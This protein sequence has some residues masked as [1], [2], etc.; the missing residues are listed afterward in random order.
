MNQGTVVSEIGQKQLSKDVLWGITFTACLT[1]A[2]LYLP[3]GF[4]IGLLIPLPLIFY[5]IKLGRLLS[6]LILCTVLA[7]VWMIFR[8]AGAQSGIFFLYFGLTGVILAEALARNL[9]VEKTVLVTVGVVLGAGAILLFA[10]TLFAPESFN[11]LTKTYLRENI[12]LAIA[13]YKDMGV[14]QEKIE[15]LQNSLESILYISIHIIPGFF[16]AFTL[17]TVWVNLLITRLILKKGHLFCPDFGSLNRWKSPEH[18]V[19]VAIGS[20]FLLLF[21]LSGLKV[22]GLNGL[23]VLIV[24]YMFQ[25]LAIISYYFEKKKFP[26]ILRGGIYTLLALQPFLIAAVMLAGF[27]DVWADFRCLKKQQ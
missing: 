23:I 16:V 17:F 4:V 19:W 12:E 9:S 5:R 14:P 10:Y 24:V 2:A 20:G 11:V 7:I 26:L 15:I 18:L 22:L 8:K 6:A 21:P 3:V 27:L 13:L 25:G 1:V